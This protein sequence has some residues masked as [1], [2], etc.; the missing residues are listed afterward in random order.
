MRF[1]DSNLSRGRHASPVGKSAR[2]K[3]LIQSMPPRSQHTLARPAVVTG[4][5][6]WSGREV[7]VELLPAPP[8][9]GVVFV[10]SDLEKP[11]RIPAHVSYRIETPRRTVLKHQGATVE[12]VE[13]VMAALSAL[14][15]DNCEVRVDQSE[16]PGCDGSSQAYVEA[17]DVA[18]VVRQSSPRA[19][20]V[21]R[22]VARVGA[23]HAWIEASPALHHGISFKYH[24]DYGQDNAIG[25]QTLS[26]DVTPDVFRQEL[27]SSRT[28]L[29]KSEADWLRTQ[30]LASKA[31]AK[32]LLIFGDQG[33]IDNELRFPDECVRHKALDLIGD[34]ALGGCDIVG[35]FV[36]HKTGHRLN[37]EL[38]RV[39]LQEGEI[40][41][42]RRR[43]A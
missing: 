41:G 27:A 8:D 37:A 5:G 10:R 3:K 36:A 15:V 2:A 7:R 32:D 43:T 1:E 20:L 11:A 19:Q 38:L 6:Y 13:H 12:M 42:Q 16:L 24:L 33:P 17:I 18:G 34:L 31:T 30:G 14:Q 29:L 21:V 28:F 40:T 39:L 35:H 26:L 4:V 22:E 23:E 25:R 9:T